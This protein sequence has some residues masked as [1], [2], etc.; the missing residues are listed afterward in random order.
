MMAENQRV[1]SVAEAS[2]PPGSEGCPRKSED[3]EKTS[4]NRS[5]D[6]ENGSHANDRDSEYS[7]PR[8]GNAYVRLHSLNRHIRFECGVEPRF[9]CPI[10]HKKSKHKHNL[11]LHMR[12]HQKL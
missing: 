1:E 2:E 11:I 12:T 5:N 4:E 9:E 3:A 10:C 7:C 8:C 6:A